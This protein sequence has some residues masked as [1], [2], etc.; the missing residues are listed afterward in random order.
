MLTET[1][2]SNLQ[3]KL[4][5]KPKPKKNNQPFVTIIITAMIFVVSLVF[6]FFLKGNQ[7]TRVHS[8][9]DV[10]IPTDDRIEFLAKGLTEDAAFDLERK[11]ILEIGRKDKGTGPLLNRTS[12]GQGTSGILEAAAWPQV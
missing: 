9:H 4:K 5:L 11:T 8:K 7:E 1:P 12:G 6:I 2:K 10:E 3:P